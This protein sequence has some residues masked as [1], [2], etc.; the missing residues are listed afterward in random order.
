[1]SA[2]ERKKFLT[3]NN[4]ESVKFLKLLLKKN[5]ATR[6]HSKTCIVCVRSD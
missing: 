5:P 2:E 3:E 1:M 6:P 4:G